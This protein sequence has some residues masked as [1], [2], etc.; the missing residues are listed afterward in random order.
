[1]SGVVERGGRVRR[2]GGLVLVLRGV[3]GGLRGLSVGFVMVFWVGCGLGVVE[4]GVLG[5]VVCCRGE[6]G[7]AGV[8]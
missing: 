1:M 7:T 5:E 4:T 8:L 6:S 3:G 2:R